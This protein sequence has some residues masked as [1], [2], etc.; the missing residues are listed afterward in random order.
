MF[1]CR[2]WT[3]LH[4]AVYFNYPS[5]MLSLILDKYTENYLNFPSKNEE[6]A[7][8]LAARKGNKIAAIALVQAG[9]NVDAL[10]CKNYTPL[11]TALNYHKDGVSRIIVYGGADVNIAVDDESPL[12]IA[13]ARESLSLVRLFL[14]H[15]AFV[16]K[17]GE[18][19]LNWT[20]I[21]TMCTTGKC[22]IIIVRTLCCCNII[23]LEK[24][25]NKTK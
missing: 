13:V 3:C 14:E 20:S 23:K 17:P 8:H 19:D 1:L 6:T 5:S 16:V 12:I 21:H 15:G 24:S 2:F 25:A 11:L 10:D 9:A 22:I 4:Y 7:L 18:K